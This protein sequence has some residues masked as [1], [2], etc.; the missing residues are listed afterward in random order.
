MQQKAPSKKLITP[1]NM[2][3]K[4]ETVAT[5]V[6]QGILPLF[7]HQSA[8]VSADVVRTLYKA[9]IRAIEYT[10]RGEAALE[11]F[12]ILKK[13]QQ[14][15][16]TDLLLGIGTIKTT[17]EANEFIDS[18]ADFI[19]SPIVNPDVAAIAINNGLI[20]IPGCM[21]PTEMHTAL[22]HG[23]SLVKLFPAN[24]LGPAFVSAVKEIFPALQIM[25]TGGV[26]M[27]QQNIT[28]WFNAG[29]SAVGMGSKLITKAILG[30]K[31]Y[32]QLYIDTLQALQY[33]QAAR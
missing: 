20:W 4:Y 33:V 2:K 12:K 13:L 19:I 11:N 32:N 17:R 25:P 23:A 22:S 26:E 27:N 31:D 21:T 6:N 18:G 8:E 3:G 7:F 9:G 16:L 30:S 29:V 14:D 1:L 28:S 24:I 15:E 5:I 10:N